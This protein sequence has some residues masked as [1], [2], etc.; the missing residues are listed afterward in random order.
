MQILILPGFS[1]WARQPA[2]ARSDRTTLFLD[3]RFLLVVSLSTCSDDSSAVN[4]CASSKHFSDLDMWQTD[5]HHN[6]KN[7]LPKQIWNRVCKRH[8]RQSFK[9]SWHQAISTENSWAE[10]GRDGTTLRAVE[11]S[12]KNW[13][14]L[15]WFE[16]RWE[17]VITIEKGWGKTTS[18]SEN[19][20]AKLSE[21]SWHLLLGKTSFWDPIAARFL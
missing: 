11:K 3:T 6:G 16:K 17:A 21:V 20:V 14:E 5:F 7:A 10:R 8:Q 1:T 13:E 12:C 19:R 9:V 15:R 2:L 4:C 18:N